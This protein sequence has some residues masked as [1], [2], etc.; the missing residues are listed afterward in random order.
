LPIAIGEDE[1]R[2]L[3][4]PLGAVPP[5][6]VH[7]SAKLLAR[8]PADVPAARWH[9]CIRDAV[10]F[11]DEWGEAAV[12]LGWSVDDLFGLDPVAPLARY[13]NMGMLWLLKGERV[14]ALTSTEARFASL[15]FYRKTHARPL[16]RSA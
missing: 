12:S 9:R 1:R 8:A 14:I 5:A 3:A 2:T 13:D 4:I 16:R 15:T 6:Y 7:A 11:L 10:E